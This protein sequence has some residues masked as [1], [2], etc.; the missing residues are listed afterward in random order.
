MVA[1][2]VIASFSIDLDMTTGLDGTLTLF[3]DTIGVSEV[4]FEDITYGAC[5][6]SP[7]GGSIILNSADGSSGTITYNSDCTVTGTWLDSSGGAGSF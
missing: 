3:H 6:D 5:G 7:D 1:P 4:I 2:I